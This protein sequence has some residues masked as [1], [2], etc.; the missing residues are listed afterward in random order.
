MDAIVKTGFK[1]YVAQ[2]FM[3][4]GKTNDEKIAALKDAVR[5]CDV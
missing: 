1:D 5:R 3:P 4:T 2:E